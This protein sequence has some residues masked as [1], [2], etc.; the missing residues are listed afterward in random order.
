MTQNNQEHEFG[1]TTC[2]QNFDIEAIDYFERTTKA[3][4]I[5]LKIRKTKKVGLIFT[6][7]SIMYEW[8]IRHGKNHNWFNV[9][10]EE[11]RIKAEKELLLKL[12]NIPIL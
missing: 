5:P 4:F 10:E 12:E 9:A 7:N 2:K 6:T 8:H 3:T 11:A 1:C